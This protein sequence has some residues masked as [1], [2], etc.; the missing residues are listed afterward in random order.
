MKNMV[1]LFGLIALALV[2]G[3][4][5]A[6]CG[7]GA[8]GPPGGPGDGPGGPD[9]LSG[10]ITI[11]PNTG[12]AV[13]ME[14]TA[15]Y[16]GTE[17]VSY[18]WKKG[19]TAIDDE[20][21]TTYTP[22]TAGS[23]TVTI[24]ATDYISK[25]S[26]AVTVLDGTGTK[27]D[28]F[29]LTENFWADGIIASYSG[30]VWYS[31]DVA[32][33]TTY[34]VWWNDG[35][36][37][38]G[39]GSK[40]LDIKVNA[41]YS[42]DTP[43]TT[44]FNESS[45][46]YGDSAWTTPKTI[47][48]D[49]EEDTVYLKVTAY[50]AGTGTFGVVYS[51]IG[52]TRPPVPIYPQSP[53]PLTANQWKDGS[54]TSI[55]GE[56]WYSF[57]VSSGTTYNLWWNDDGAGNG[58]KTLDVKVS[59]YYSDGTVV[60]TFTNVDSA[61]S[62]PKS[63]TSTSNGTVYLKVTSFYSNNTGTFAIVYSTGT[64]KPSL[65]FNPPSPIPLS[66]NQWKDGEITDASGG[67]QWFS[68]SVSS[69]VY[70]VW[71]N[72][73]SPNGN[74]MK[75]LNVKVSAYYS[76]G[77]TGNGF[78]STETAWSSSKVLNPT[79]SGTVYLKVVPSTSGGTGT[80]AIV[81]NTG[82]NAARPPS[83]FNPAATALTAGVWKD[84]EI[85]S[86][87]PA[88]FSLTV[89]A[90]STYYAW[91]N[92]TG[93]SYG[94][95][96]K[97]ANISVRA[98]ENDGTAISSFASTDSAWGTAKSFTPTTDGTVYIQV[99]PYSSSYIGTFG[100]VYSET[101]TKPPVPINAVAPTALTVDQWAYDTIA[102]D[103][104]GEVWYSFEASNGT[105]RVWWNDS[106]DGNGLF[107]TLDVR[108]S[109]WRSSTGDNLFY[110]ADTAWSSSQQFT[111]STNETIY[112][113]VTPK[114]AGA[115]GTFN[116]VYSTS[117]TRP[118]LPFRP[119]VSEPPNPVPLSAGVWTDGEFAAGSSGEIWY[120]IDLPASGTVYV[121]WNEVAPNGDGFKTLDI[122]GA[123]WYSNGASAFGN[124]SNAWSTNRS[125]SAT[126]DTKAYIRI[127][128][129]V[130][131]NTG[132]FGIAYNTTNTKP[133]VPFTPPVSPTPLTA[134]NWVEGTI[135]ASGEAWYSLSV[136]NGTLYCI[137]LNDR[138][139]S[140]GTEANRSGDFTKTLDIYATGWYANGAAAF[141][142]YNYSWSESGTGNSF[143]ASEAGT[144]Y[145]R[146]YPT[147]AGQTGT[148][149]IAYS[150]DGTRPP[151]P[152]PNPLPSTTTLTANT[153]VDN[154]TVTS[155][156]GVWYSFPVASGTTYHIWWNARNY[157]D[158][159]KTL[160]ARVSA[161][162]GTNGVNILD[163][164]ESGWAPANVTAFT[165]SQNDTVYV[166]VYPN[167]RDDTGT[168][169]IVY[170][171]GSYPTRPP[172]PL[173][174]YVAGSATLLTV[175]TWAHGEITAA[176]NGEVWYKFPIQN[177][178]YYYVWWNEN[179]TNSGDGTK[180]L[181]IKVSGFFDSGAVLGEGTSN[182]F[183]N[184]ETAWSAH[185]RV[186]PLGGATTVYLK[187][188]PSSSGGTGTFDI[189]FRSLTGEGEIPPRPP[190]PFNPPNPTALTAGTWASGNI[191]TSGG[192]QWFTFSATASPQYIHITF[193]TLTDFNV[194]I[195]DNSG[196]AVGN[197]T[198]MYTNTRSTSQ[199]LTAG[200]TYY[201][202]VWPYSSSGKGTYQIAF[203]TSSTAPAQ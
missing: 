86:L 158:G 35:Y 185:Q 4:S 104:N 20:T 199:P 177:G 125:F 192:Q 201:I 157:G 200:Q 150:V 127:R 77:T 19:G 65:S 38:S 75:T 103:S 60:S 128:P 61:W 105:Y 174:A 183:A 155:N 184:V 13:G 71:L 167:Y 85:T 89:T 203:N 79:K 152:L 96:T 113:K 64:T 47:S 27:A 74:G 66:A 187:V 196:A 52:T 68:L 148:Y 195:Y 90:G 1:K 163:S 168:F 154:G 41:Y 22:D 132:T 37:S 161:W 24:S 76:D 108:V 140:G 97:T 9:P 173:P 57:T 194:Q 70:N 135:A 171:S 134:A 109:A 182:V 17:T 15:T 188:M 87:E 179:G 130:A 91:W 151:V 94:N 106:Y 190:L 114:T 172:I 3:F 99:T 115:T 73:L 84:G 156:A 142:N 117:N 165:P 122:S 82:L 8:G 120:S 141:D 2:M 88:W 116:V 30:E 11:S 28:P 178:T 110:D 92:E 169:G 149:G 40:T 162:Y 202:K 32:R 107:R 31:F 189:V 59:A 83:N 72:E 14:L 80:F 180:T 176:S 164:K 153:W 25:T 126:T 34:R 95:R 136:T 166:R 44:G 137:W 147:T 111:V 100:I 193:G 49:E 18:Q 50:S 118:N 63:F 51:T 54:I 160:G 145:I 69:G 45:S 124:N 143:T 191:P 36:T 55:S 98:Y 138:S 133:I 123:A 48:P 23:Y 42:D 29:K 181:N 186:A 175:D 131:G 159:S 58:I 102:A 26:A 146:V 62:S 197:S 78:S 67:A 46:S 12:V 16:S 139:L 112:V 198:N 43:I 33:G 56:A 21:E 93:S 5:F 81:Y 170:T 144:V 10:S 121:W 101:N 119:E 39:D 129:S 7:G 53:T 6:S